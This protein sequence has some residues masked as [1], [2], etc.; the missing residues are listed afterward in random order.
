M[1]PIL[2]IPSTGSSRTSPRPTARSAS[3]DLVQRLPSL[4][5]AGQSPPSPQGVGANESDGRWLGGGRLVPPPGLPPVQC[6]LDLQSARHAQGGR[7]VVAQ[8][9]R[10]VRHVDASDLGRG[11]GSPPRT[12]SARLL[13][14]AR[15]ASGL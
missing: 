4:D 15:Q 2:L 11:T 6:E 8:P 14:Q 9:Q 12:G 13:E 3:W 10:R 5:G 7:Q 1:P